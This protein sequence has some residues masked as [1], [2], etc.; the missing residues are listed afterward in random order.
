VLLGKEK[1]FI[2]LDTYETPRRPSP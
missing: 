1:V 2:N